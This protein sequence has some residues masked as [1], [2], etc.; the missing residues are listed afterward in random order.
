MSAKLEKVV[1]IKVREPKIQDL[2]GVGAATAE[3]LEAAGYKDMMSIAVSTL[4]ELVE[5]AGVTEAVAR[6]MINF[7]RDT[8]KMGFESGTEVLKKRQLVLKLTTG[9]ASFDALMGGGFETGAIT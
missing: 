7:A 5:T 4:G 3:K 1:E 8:V 9:S 2:P 6:K